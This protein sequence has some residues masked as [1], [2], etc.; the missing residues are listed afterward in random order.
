MIKDRDKRGGQKV[1]PK[2]GGLCQ[3]KLGCQGFLPTYWLK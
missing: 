3:G 1:K 2:R